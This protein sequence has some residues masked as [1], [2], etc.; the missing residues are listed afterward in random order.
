MHQVT[1]RQAMQARVGNELSELAAG[2]DW[3]DR[4]KRASQDE[5]RAAD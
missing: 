2:A 5:G 4:I 3:R 1:A